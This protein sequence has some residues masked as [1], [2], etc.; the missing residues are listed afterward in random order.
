MGEFMG[1]SIEVLKQIRDGIETMGANVTEALGTMNRRLD[2][3]GEDIRGVN[4]RLVLV[5]ARQAETNA[6]LDETNARLDQTNARLDQT[7]A[8]LDQTNLRLD[9]MIR[10]MGGH[11]RDHDQRIR[12]LEERVDVLAGGRKAS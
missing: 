10:I 7:N 9:R 12:R 11:W 5:E 1:G 4:A 6:R 8:R 2:A 3:M